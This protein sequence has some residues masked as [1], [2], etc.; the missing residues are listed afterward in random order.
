MAKLL[1]SELKMAY[2]RRKTRPQATKMRFSL[3]DYQILCTFAPL[4]PLEGRNTLG[5]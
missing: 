2:L 1:L 4:S 3:A 5:V